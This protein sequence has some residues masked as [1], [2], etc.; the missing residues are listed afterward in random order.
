MPFFFPVDNS[1]SIIKKENTTPRK[2][3]LRPPPQPVSVPAIQ[4]KVKD[5]PDD[6]PIRLSN[7]SAERTDGLIHLQ[8]NPS[9]WG[10]VCPFHS[11]NAGKAGCDRFSTCRLIHLNNA[12]ETLFK[13]TD[14]KKFKDRFYVLRGPKDVPL[15]ARGGAA[16]AGSPTAVVAPVPSNSKVNN[17]S[18]NHT[19]NKSAATMMVNHHQHHHHGNNGDDDD[20]DDDEEVINPTTSNRQQPSSSKNKNKKGKKA[21]AAAASNDNTKPPIQVSVDVKNYPNDPAITLA[22]YDAEFTPGL[23]YAQRHPDRVVAICPFYSFN[24]GTTG[25]T[26]MNCSNIHL[27]KASATLFKATGD[28]KFKNGFFGSQPVTNSNSAKNHQQQQQVQGAAAAATATNNNNGRPP[29]IEVTVKDFPDDEPI[30]LTDYKA[31]PTC[32]LNGLIN[33]N[34]SIGIVCPYYSFNGGDVCHKGK[35]CGYIHLDDAS[36]TLFKATRD[37]KFKGSF[38]VKGPSSSSNNNKKNRNDHDDD[39][40]SNGNSSGIMSAPNLPSSPSAPSSPTRISNRPADFK[41]Y[42]PP[43]RAF[44]FAQT[45]GEAPHT[46]VLDYEVGL[47]RYDPPSDKFDANTLPRNKSEAMNPKYRHAADLPS[48]RNNLRD[49]GAILL[50]PEK[51]AVLPQ[52]E[53]HPTAVQLSKLKPSRYRNL[54]HMRLWTDEIRRRVDLL[55]FSQENLRAAKGQILPAVRGDRPDFVR[56]TIPGVAESRPSVLRGDQ[57]LCSVHGEDRWD[58]GVVHFVN[59]DVVI[60]AF[61]STAAIRDPHKRMTQGF[62]VQFTFGNRTL[63][64][65]V[66]RAIDIG[67]HLNRK[68]IESMDQRCTFWKVGNIANSNRISNRPLNEEQ[69]AFVTNVCST[70]AAH[71]LSGPPGTGKTVSIVAAILAVYELSRVNKVRCKILVACPT[72]AAADLIVERIDDV[73]STWDSGKPSMQR[74]HALNRQVEHTSQEVRKH[75][76]ISNDNFSFPEKSTINNLSIVVCTLAS[77]ARMYSRG[78][79]TDHFTHVFVD[80][81]GQVTEEEMMIATT[82]VPNPLDSLGPND[83]A[84]S[85][86]LAGDVY[87]LG[88]IIAAAATREAGM[89][90]SALER[91][92]HVASQANIVHLVCNY[93]S[94]PSI[95]RIVNVTYHDKLIPSRDYT[96]NGNGNYSSHFAGAAVAAATDHSLALLPQHSPLMRQKIRDPAIAQALGNSF[97]KNPVMFIHSE[98]PECRDDESPSWQN[99]SEQFLVVDLVRTLIN[100][101]GKKCK[102]ITVLT[103]YIAQRKKIDSA[104]HFLCFDERCDPADRIKI[105]NKERSANTSYSATGKAR[106]KSPVHVCTVEA[107]QGKE[108]RIIIVSCVRSQETKNI[109]TDIKFALGFLSQYQRTNVA[110]SRA[111]DAMIIIGNSSIFLR[112]P[113]RLPGAATNGGTYDRHDRTTAGLWDGYLQ[114]I[115]DFAERTAPQVLPSD[116]QRPRYFDDADDDDYQGPVVVQPG[117]LVSNFVNLANPKQTLD[118]LRASLGRLAY[119]NR[120]SAAAATDSNNDDDG[121]GSIID[122]NDDDENGFDEGQAQVREE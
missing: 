115:S 118:D 55:Q 89:G 114:R 106:T 59:T 74:I 67:T 96:N 110:L 112:D 116:R 85:L 53:L 51:F 37:A 77:A 18:N 97:S 25:C 87:Q 39:D 108:N 84:T 65:S 48:I 92:I 75:S 16:T 31:A 99:K 71:I 50:T 7:Y 36:R 119:A 21:A 105:N 86:I 27:N 13:A 19:N 98:G 82:F 26:T 93:R 88:P 63:I 20:D 94:H 44:A 6:S 42:A 49:A 103:P 30:V 81:A 122:D 2:L 11:F 23:S 102:D 100:V 111:Q 35:N 113:A 83:R 45:F 104:L 57:I 117:K 47:D 10:Y 5:F 22:E 76:D 78:I 70:A 61:H 3:M 95:V 79:A 17:N 15:Q 101:C 64:R 107:F 80:E 121:D 41:E 52:N 72:N 40:D 8:Q 29:K 73:I 33:G 91:L 28:K 56:I 12:A 68:V 109:N 4:V 46:Q 43:R 66:H 14:D 32:G 120:E 38:Y 9:E 34:K 1:Q 69:A 58:G 60:V 90:V 24:T 54:L 62:D